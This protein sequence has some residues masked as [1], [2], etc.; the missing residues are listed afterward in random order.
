MFEYDQG[1]GEAP[2]VQDHAQEVEVCVFSFG[3]LRGE[4]VVAEE[5]DSRSELSGQSGL[6]GGDCVGEVLNDEVEL[7]ECGGDGD[8]GVATGAADVYN[9]GGAQGSPVK[10]GEEVFEAG[11]FA[12][13][14]AFHVAGEL[15]CQVRGFCEVVEE[16]EVGVHDEVV[17]CFVFL[18]CGTPIFGCFDEFVGGCGGC[19]DHE[20]S[21]VVKTVVGD[22]GC[23][24]GI[25]RQLSGVCFAEE[26]V[27]H[28]H[29]SDSSEL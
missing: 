5:G 6:G 25:V 7:W 20:E 4:E 14:D 3:G 8:G 12:G 11:A 2:V 21:P 16:G 10:A 9:G 19:I 22:E 26:V 27:R 15:F 13:G 17:G 24:C 1:L 23:R 28:S 29:A 18:L